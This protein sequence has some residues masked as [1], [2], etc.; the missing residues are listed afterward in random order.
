MLGPGHTKKDAVEFTL[1]RPASSWPKRSVRSHQKL[2]HL[3][4]GF[5]F[6]LKNL[7]TRTKFNVFVPLS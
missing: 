7:F 4:A 5:T 2:G 1:G 3:L 6:A